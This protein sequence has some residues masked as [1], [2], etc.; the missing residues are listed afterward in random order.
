MRWC[1]SA[2]FGSN[3][4]LGHCATFRR[5]GI[6]DKGA[7]IASK[8]VLTKGNS[9]KYHWN[10]KASNGQVIASSES[11]ESKRAALAG[12]ESVKKNASGASVED[13]TES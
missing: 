6:G 5:Q 13:T 2:I 9:G 1:P 3:H 7:A 10:L 4:R 12:I 8:F 11:Y